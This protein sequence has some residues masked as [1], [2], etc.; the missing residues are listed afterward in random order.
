MIGMGEVSAVM[1]AVD[2]ERFGPRHVG[3]QPGHGRA[4]VRCAPLA[5][6]AEEG[7]HGESR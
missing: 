7:G 2:L 6:H 5:A 3:A 4:M 1:G